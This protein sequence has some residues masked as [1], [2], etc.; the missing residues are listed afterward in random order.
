MSI[1][2][3][4]RSSNTEGNDMTKRQ[5]IDRANRATYRTGNELFVI[6][7]YEYE[8]YVVCDYWALVTHYDHDS[9]IYSI[10]E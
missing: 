10:Y 5:A 7:D 9:V 1:I 8:T 3:I 2:D 4:E 6:W